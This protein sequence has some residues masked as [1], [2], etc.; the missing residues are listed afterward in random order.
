MDAPNLEAVLEEARI[1]GLADLE[2][3][4]DDFVFVATDINE[5]AARNCAPRGALVLSTKVAR[6]HAENG[7]LT[8]RTVLVIPS[9]ERGALSRAQDLIKKI[10]GKVARAVLLV[11]PRVS[12]GVSLADWFATGH[13]LKELNDL[14][15]DAVQA[16]DNA[17]LAAFTWSDDV[18]LAKRARFLIEQVLPAQGIGHLYAPSYVGKSLVA[19]DLAMC[20]GT[21]KPFSG[22]YGAQPGIAVYLALEGED[23][24]ADRHVAYRQ[25]HDVAKARLAFVNYPLDIC[26]AKS[27]SGFVSLLKD[28]SKIKGAPISLVVIDTLAMAMAGHD[29]TKD[30][31]AAVKGMKAIQAATGG[32]VLSVHHTG[33]DETRGMRGGSAAFA[34]VDFV[35]RIKDGA[36]D[37]LRT[38]HREKLKNGQPVDLASFQIQSMHLGQDESDK[39]I[40][41]P[42]LEWLPEIAPE[43]RKAKLAPQERYLIDALHECIITNKVQPSRGNPDVPDGVQ[44][45]TGEVLLAAY[46]EKIKLDPKQRDTKEAKGAFRSIVSRLRNKK[47]VLG[48]NGGYVW[49]IEG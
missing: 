7:Y 30:M 19:H 27:V 17:R 6:A 28:C 35:L 1:I 46:H 26:D 41:A 25:K 37:K 29:E 39:P 12:E 9:G 32:C 45:V 43:T 22:K 5:A 40:V 36:E 33:K 38:L 16:D 14:A 13:T 20:V 44:A 34:N 11:L 3:Y 48:G 10:S 42:V 49:E 47:Q 31:P 23:S 4:P 18:E 15:H 8:E 21:G 24:M 2:N